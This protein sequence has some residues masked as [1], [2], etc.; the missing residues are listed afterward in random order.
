MSAGFRLSWTF[1][2]F[3]IAVKNLCQTSAKASELILGGIVS[4]TVVFLGLQL[5]YFLNIS[6]F[7]SWFTTLSS[8]L[9]FVNNDS[10]PVYISVKYMW[11]TTTNKVTWLI[12]QV[13]RWLTNTLVAVRSMA[14]KFCRAMASDEGLLSTESIITWSWGHMTNK[15]RYITTSTRSMATR[16]YSN[17]AYKKGS[18]PTNGYN[19]IVTWWIKN[20]IY[21]LPQCLWLPNLTR[22][23][24]TIRGRHAQSHLIFWSIDDM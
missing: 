5:N 2:V 6:N 7:F 4:L 1:L 17:L 20:V 21:L 22:W 18:P 19:I 11:G 9:H 23:L 12:D 24:L 13:V 10:S 15:N 8:P 14:T 16:I 3:N